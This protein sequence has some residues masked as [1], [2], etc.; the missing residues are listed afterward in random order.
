MFEQT[1]WL[2]KL[3][4]P[5]ANRVLSR[6]IDDEETQH[7]TPAAPAEAGPSRVRVARVEPAGAATA[8][9]HSNALDRP[10]S[11]PKLRCTVAPAVVRFSSVADREG[12]IGVRHRRRRALTWGWRSKKNDSAESHRLSAASR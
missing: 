4:F 7:G 6:P 10:N 12:L 5:V 1:L 8:V 9:C 11:R 2:H 3:I